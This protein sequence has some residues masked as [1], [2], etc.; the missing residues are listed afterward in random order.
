M[1][2]SAPVIGIENLIPLL[3]NRKAQ[4]KIINTLILL[5]RNPFNSPHF[6]ANIKYYKQNKISIEEQAKEVKK[7]IIILFSAI[8][9]YSFFSEDPI[10]RSNIGFS[11]IKDMKVEP[12]PEFA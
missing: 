11:G 9:T 2:D 8:H 3:E 5:L 4:E 10:L 1:Y 7:K 6:P 12:K